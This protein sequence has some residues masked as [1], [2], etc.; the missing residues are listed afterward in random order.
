MPGRNLLSSALTAVTNQTVVSY[1]EYMERRSDSSYLFHKLNSDAL[2]QSHLVGG[3]VSTDEGDLVEVDV[4]MD[5]D[6]VEDNMTI[7]VR[8]LTGKVLNIGC[9]PTTNIEKIKAKIQARESIPVDQQRLIFAGKQLEDGRSLSDYNI[10]RDSTLHLVLR[11]RG[12]GG[13]LNYFL[14]PELLDPGYDFDFTDI[15]DTGSIF[16][17]GGFEYRRPCGW[18]RIALKVLDKYDSDNK[19]LGTASSRFRYDS[20]PGEWPVS[21]HGT[22]KHWNSSIA[23]D[24]LRLSK[25]QG[26]QFP[27]SQGIYTTP[28][29]NLA[30]NYAETFT[31][32]GAQYKIV[33]QN[34]VNPDTLSI[35][36]T[37]CGDYWISPRGT[38]VRPYGIL[39]KKV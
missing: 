22:S 26:I 18:K 16:T 24:G 34:R 6:N 14:S 33:F 23:D 29:V 39:I 19:W 31:H 13:A 35:L 32:E 9:K 11:L 25:E 10:T 12:G 1:E 3:I 28:D 7:F 15:N 37:G 4:E 5:D 21:Y 17:R 2:H 8:T 30:A 36:N 27:Y 38:D 20:E